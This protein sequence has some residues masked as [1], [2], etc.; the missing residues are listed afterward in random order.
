[1]SAPDTIGRGVTVGTRRTIVAP[2]GEEVTT[3]GVKMTTEGIAFGVTIKDSNGEKQYVATMDNDNVAAIIGR[4]MTYLMSRLT[5]R[6]P[7]A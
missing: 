1:V 7:K 2:K 5:A 4:G 3:F 6:P